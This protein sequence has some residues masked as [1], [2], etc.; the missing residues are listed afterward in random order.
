MDG[1]VRS[2]SKMTDKKMN[3]AE[4]TPKT[5]LLDTHR[6]KTIQTEHPIV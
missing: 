4:D 1:R 5:S 3:E 6:V 2:S